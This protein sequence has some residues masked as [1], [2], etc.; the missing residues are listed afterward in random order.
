MDTLIIGN[1]LQQRSSRGA[2]RP[3]AENRYYEAHRP[4]RRDPFPPVASLTLI[5]ALVLILAA[6]TL[7]G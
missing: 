3:D 6:S 7:G 1:L 5:V 2:G 4:R